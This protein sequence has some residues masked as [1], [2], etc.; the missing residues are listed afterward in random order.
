MAQQQPKQFIHKNGV[1]TLNPEYLT[2]KRNGGTTSPTPWQDPIDK[3]IVNIKVL[4]A[5]DLVAKDRNMFGKKTSSDP[6]VLVS[7]S[8]TSSS[9]VSNENERLKKTEKVELGRTPTISKDLSPTWNY[10]Q[11][12]VIPISRAHESLQLEFEIF[13]QDMLSADDS[14]GVVKLEALKWM[15]SSRPCVWYD[16]PK[17]SAKDCTGKIKISV[18]TFLH[19][20]PGLTPY[21]C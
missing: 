12:S 11:K 8:E 14:L 16:I 10:S 2:W 7:L 9:T 4:K 17:D 20:M 21:C 15:N 19:R 3:M 6:Y 18:S 13:D 5:E 1:I